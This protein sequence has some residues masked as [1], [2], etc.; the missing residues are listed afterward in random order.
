[1]KKF[2]LAVVSVLTVLAMVFCLAACG[3]TPEQKLNAYI[4]S[5]AFQSQLTSMKSSFGSMMDM[6]VRA[7]DNK[8]VYE[9]TYKT[10]IESTL[11]DAVKSQLDTTF[12]SMSSTF[13]GVADEIKEVVGIEN[14][15]VVIR[16]LNADKTEITTIEFGTSK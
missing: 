10:Q 4:E 8:L 1:M 2:T 16:L 15:A 5:E 7:E 9:I 12:Q 3:Q 11:V 6:D 14:P 13:E